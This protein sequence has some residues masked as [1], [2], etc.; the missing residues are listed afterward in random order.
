M[1]ST[2]SRASRSSGTSCPDCG[3]GWTRLEVARATQIGA[4]PGAKLLCHLVGVA[5]Q[6]LGAVL[7]QLGDGRLGRVPVPRTILIEV[8]RRTGQPPQRIA[9]HSGRLAR[10]HAPELHPAVLEPLMSSL[11]RGRGTE[12]DGPCDA[13]ASGELAE[14]RYLS[15]ESATAANRV[16]PRL[17][18]SPAPSC[19]AGIGSARTALADRR[20]RCSRAGSADSG[21]PSPTGSESRTPSAAARPG[22]RWNFTSV[23]QSV[24]KRSKISG[25]IG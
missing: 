5:L 1:P 20:S 7:G 6:Q 3:R 16:R 4:K 8:G 15:V 23:D 22:W 2:T 13:P 12:I 18:R 10:H 24:Y 17:S 14:V 11:G 21:R 19:P 9:E 25:C